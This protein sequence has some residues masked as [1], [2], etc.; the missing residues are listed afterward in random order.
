[1]SNNKKIRTFLFSLIYIAIYG[2]VSYSVFTWLFEYSRLFAYL[3]NLALII[4]VLAM[5]ELTLKMIQSEKYITQIMKDEN[6]PRE[7]FNSL[8]MGLNNSFSFK[9]DLHLFYVFILIASQIIELYP[10]LVGEKLGNFIF[11]NNYSILLLIAF[12]TLVSQFSKD[13]ERIDKILELFKKSM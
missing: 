6:D 11:A 7:K 10:T 12:D 4:I 3:G 5:D 2:F 1:M 9:T 8:Q 13:R